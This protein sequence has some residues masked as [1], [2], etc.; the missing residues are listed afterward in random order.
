MKI[1]THI[2]VRSHFR[3]LSQTKQWI[4]Y[5][6][7]KAYHYASNDKCC[8]YWADYYSIAEYKGKLKY[9]EETRTWNRNK[10]SKT[11]GLHC[12]HLI[13]LTIVIQKTFL[14]YDSLSNIN[15]IECPLHP[16][17]FRTIF[18]SLEKVW[19]IFFVF[20]IY[21]KINIW[22]KQNIRDLICVNKC[23]FMMF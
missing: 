22:C 10:C 1:W 19:E 6:Q 11:L 14:V 20:C 15:D 3:S 12:I 21:F 4:I 23:I 16:W 7:C 17:Y 2:S 13:I 18:Y 5:L 9:L 8:F